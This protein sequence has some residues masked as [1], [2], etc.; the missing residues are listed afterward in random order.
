VCIPLILPV[1]FLVV[2]EFSSYRSRDFLRG[3][4][5]SLID[6]FNP[7]FAQH[8]QLEDK[9]KFVQDESLEGG[10]QRVARFGN[11]SLWRTFSKSVILAGTDSESP[12]LK[13]EKTQ[14]QRDQNLFRPDIGP[15]YW[16]YDHNQVTI[17]APLKFNP[18]IGHF[19]L[20]YHTFAESKDTR[21][22][23]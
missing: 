9:L 4:S 1:I 6:H 16:N 7:S 17:T 18:A 11:V 22:S 15:G 8:S 5:I 21:I 14:V 10:W 20:S 23:E 19:F 13:L 12:I 2:R 3:D